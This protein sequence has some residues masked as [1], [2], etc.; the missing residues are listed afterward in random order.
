[1][2]K[3]FTVRVGADDAAKFIE[4]YDGPNVFASTAFDKV[5]DTEIKVDGV[6]FLVKDAV[7]LQGGYA[8]ELMLEQLEEDCD[9]D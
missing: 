6:P 1:M 3:A 7:V 4:G 9:C 8:A 2:T 5:I